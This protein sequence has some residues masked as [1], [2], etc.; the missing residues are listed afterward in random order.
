MVCGARRRFV[1]RCLGLGN[2]A[3]GGG[4]AGSI[5]FRIEPA[6]ITTEFIAARAADLE[7][8]R[9]LSVRH[10]FAASVVGYGGNRSNAQRV[11]FPLQIPTQ[12]LRLAGAVAAVDGFAAIL[13]GLSAA[14]GSR[15]DGCSNAATRRAGRHP[16]RHV[17]ELERATD[18]S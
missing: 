8:R 16:R 14:V 18:F 9:Q 10:A 15:G 12:F 11:L 3:D 2:F 4:V 5:Q 7:L 13:S 6:S 1:G 17:F